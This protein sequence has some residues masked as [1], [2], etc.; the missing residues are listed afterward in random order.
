VYVGSSLQKIVV[1][2]GF[3]DPT[4]PTGIKCEGTGFLF[5]YKQQGYLLTCRHV[6]DT[7]DGAPFVIRVNRGG[8]AVLLEANNVAWDRHPDPL[9]DLAA[10]PV[11]LPTSHGYDCT[12]L[13]DDTILKPEHFDAEGIG[14]GSLCYTFG[15]FHFIQG[16]NQN[17]PMVHAGNIAL[18]PPPGERIPVHNKKTNKPD[19]VEAY[20]IESAAING[21]SGA[22]VFVRPTITVGPFKSDQGV[23]FRSSW[24]EAST[25]LLGV[26]QGAWFA[27]PD[28]AVASNVR[29]SSGSVVPVGVGLVVPA[30]AIIDLL[31][32]D[33]M[34]KHREENPPQARWA[35]LTSVSSDAAPPASN[36][37]P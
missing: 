30:H 24:P 12:Y 18:L 33:V 7:L 25:R 36:A 14:V 9:V 27:P 3:A 28:S 2:I 32:T 31:E 13:G 4:S 5:A 8:K 35:T 37:Q 23:E 17:L 26:F 10:I 21:A 11:L 34:K 20:L 1:F 29:T 15:L 6:A 16:Q 22:P 19:F